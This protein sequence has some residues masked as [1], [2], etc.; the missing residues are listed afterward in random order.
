MRQAM[1]S[2]R[3]ITWGA[4]ERA[5][6]VTYPCENEGDPGEPVVFQTHF[7]TATG[8]GKFVPADIIPAAERP[9]KEYPMVLI[10]GRQLEHWH[11]G[12]MTRRSGA[13]DAIEPEAVASLHPADVAKIGARPGDVVT[14]ES[15]R[16]KISLYIREDSGTPQ[17][18]VFIPFAFYEAAAN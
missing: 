12:A 7:P 6:S 3:G 5:T 10:T 16:G 17:G 13:L 9:D 4:L 18:A 2:L 1:D 8:R 14:V 15:R 11:T